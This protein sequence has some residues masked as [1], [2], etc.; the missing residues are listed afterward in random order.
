MTKYSVVSWIDSGTD[1]DSDGE[2]GEFQ[3]KFVA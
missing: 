1:L 3:V 2:N